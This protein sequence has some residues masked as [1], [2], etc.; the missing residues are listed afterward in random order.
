[1]VQPFKICVHLPHLRYLR[2]ILHVRIILFSSLLAGLA[3][4]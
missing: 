2:A 4:N 1:M 3:E